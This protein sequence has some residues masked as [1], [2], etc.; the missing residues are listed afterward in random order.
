MNENK[1]HIDHLTPELIDQYYK[2]Q[3]SEKDQYAVE[4][5]MLNS[6]FENEA[7]EGFDEY[8]G[9]LMGD[10]KTINSRLEERISKEKDDSVFFYIKIAASILLLALSTYLAWDI[11]NDTDK[12][13]IAQNELVQAPEEHPRSSE[14][15]LK[16]EAITIETDAPPKIPETKSPAS[17]LKTDKK[18]SN[19]VEVTD[20]L[21]VEFN[22]LIA[23][24]TT[25]DDE[26]VIQE[27]EEVAGMG[28][29]AEEESTSE[30]MDAA[31]AVMAIKEED[32]IDSSV[33]N[34]LNDKIASV[35]IEKQDVVPSNLDQLE[36]VSESQSSRVSKSRKKSIARNDD[37]N[38]AASPKSAPSTIRG[39]VTSIEDGQPL[40]G[41]NVVIKGSTTG[42]VTDIEG[43]FKLD[44]MLSNENNIL[45]IS[46]IG[47]AT[48]EIEIGDKSQID[49]Q[50]GND[51]S[52]LSEVVVVG[53]GTSD[54]V[55]NSIST[56]NNSRP[57]IP[58]SEFR[59]YLKEN[60]RYNSDLSIK[61]KVTVRFDI[62]EN[63]K[64]VN[65]EIR[66]SL[67]DY[68]DQETIRLIK[69]GPEWLPAEQ[70]DNKVKS[71]ARVTVWV[72][73][74]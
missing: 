43:N 36:S 31:K 62:L 22:D 30:R 72:E 67:N 1:N 10:L 42:T 57:S 38:I 66:K 61:G 26:M 60:T 2:G 70:N 23:D 16:E 69:E 24:N 63:G 39:K 65:F 14:P 13:Q 21:D 7:M 58:M 33:M 17:E 20:N 49:I 74:K 9:D 6:S 73:Q 35:P 44:D 68:Y 56:W 27:L 51:V 19:Q 50:M 46:F 59:D 28:I 8:E 45:I 48:E 5:L 4:K 37:Q 25:A 47:L 53:Y 34:Q 32:I 64:L 12:T 29:G 15:T 71:T 40:L 11:A 54:E 52:Q 3:L 55:D 18:P 41:V